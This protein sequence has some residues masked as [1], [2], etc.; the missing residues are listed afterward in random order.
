MTGTNF[1]NITLT[2]SDGVAT[3]RLNRPD[4]A[5]GMTLAM[6]QDLLQAT[7]ACDGDPSIRA[8]VLT[9]NGKMFCAGGD[10]NSFAALGD[11]VRDGLSEMATMLHAAVSRLARMEKPVIV[12]VNGMAAG[13]GLSLAMIGDIV[14]G[15][16]SSKY[17]MA[18]T[19]AGLTPDGSS[20]YFLP[21]LIGLRRTQELMLTNRRLS[22]EEALD[23]GLLTRIVPDDDLM[24]EADAI[25]RT[26][27]NGP[28]RAFGK[29]KHLLT[30]TFDNGLEKQMELE[31]RTIAAQAASPDGQEGINAFLE[32]R[33]PNFTGI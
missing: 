32:K 9:G 13:G 7:T 26:L 31:G 18:Y 15:A 20:T 17:T 27:A 22:A 33:A 3:I 19:G 29:V 16:A 21:R 10:L 28:T 24:T 6:M 30:E 23:W 4:A 1:E 8:V 14:L 2:T 11:K 25:A 5:N 12:A